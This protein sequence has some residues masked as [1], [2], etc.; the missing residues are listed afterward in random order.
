MTHSR[1]TWRITCTWTDPRPPFSSGPRWTWIKLGP[2]A[3]QTSG[4]SGGSPGYIYEDAWPHSH[5]DPHTHAELQLQNHRQ[6]TVHTH[7]VHSL[8]CH[9]FLQTSKNPL[10]EVKLASTAKRPTYA[11]NS[12]INLN[13]ELMLN[14]E[15]WDNFLHHLTKYT[16]S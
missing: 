8:P 7:M 14:Y 11:S 1:H 10:P 15:S 13:R 9:A 4:L 5:L 2:S 6:D 16:K 3:I 12:Y